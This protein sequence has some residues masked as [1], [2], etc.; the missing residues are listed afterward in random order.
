MQEFHTGL[1]YTKRSQFFKM[2]ESYL[3]QVG[4]ETYPYQDHLT[5]IKLI[6]EYLEKKRTDDGNNKTVNSKHERL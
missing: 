2:C 1:A 6:I 5:C 4:F 3:C